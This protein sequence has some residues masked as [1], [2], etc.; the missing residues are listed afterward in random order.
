[1]S[2]IVTY[3]VELKDKFSAKIQNLSD[4]SNRLQRKFSAVTRISNLTNSGIKTLSFSANDLKEKIAE[5]RRQSELIPVGEITKIRRYNSEIK[6]LSGQL[7]K[8]ETLNGSW[9]KTK[10]SEAFILRF[11]GSKRDLHFYNLLI[12]P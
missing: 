9:L 3:I 2:N 8:L 7:N 4:S 5:L 1:M 12:E 6:R 10:M 11:D